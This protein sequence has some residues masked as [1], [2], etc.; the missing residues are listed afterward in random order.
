MHVGV[1]AFAQFGQL[2]ALVVQ[3]VQ[4]Q[5]LGA[6]VKERV[7]AV[8]AAQQAVDFLDGRKRLP[9]HVAAQARTLAAGAVLQNF[10][11]IVFGFP[12]MLLLTFSP[13]GTLQSFI[14]LG[15]LALMFVGFNVLLIRK[16][17]FKKMKEQ[18]GV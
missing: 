11:A 6:G 14:T 13:L 7:R 17:I 8:G 4:G 5:L 12:L 3:Q 1:E 15:I 16:K 9:L 10:P 18:E 2:L